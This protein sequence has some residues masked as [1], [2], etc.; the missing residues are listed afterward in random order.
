MLRARPRSIATARPYL[1]E[2]LALLDE[3][4]LSQRADLL[5]G[6]ELFP[7]VVF[8]CRWAQDFDEERWVRHRVSQPVF[9]IQLGSAADH[10]DVRIRRKAGRQHSDAQV[11]CVSL[12]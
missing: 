12:I 10:A 7:T 8:F 2:R 9:G 1:D 11:R 4:D 6:G 3:D 5:I